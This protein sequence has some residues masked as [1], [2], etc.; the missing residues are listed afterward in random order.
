MEKRQAATLAR[1]EQQKEDAKQKE[2]TRVQVELEK[3]AKKERQVQAMR[4]ARKQKE[5]RAMERERELRAQRRVEA[6]RSK[7][8]FAMRYSCCL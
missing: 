1:I 5:T 6:E 8:N 7:L 3:A 4:A 2:L